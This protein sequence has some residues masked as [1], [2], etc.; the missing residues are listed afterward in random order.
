LAEPITIKV[1]Q[2]SQGPDDAIESYP[3]E[4][5]VNARQGGTVIVIAA[6]I[7]GV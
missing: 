4:V 5:E 3:V 1:S 7:G 2:N 6:M